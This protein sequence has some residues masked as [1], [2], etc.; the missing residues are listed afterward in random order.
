MSRVA[1]VTGAN[2]GIGR[3]VARQLASAGWTVLAG[4]RRD[5]VTAAS[6][7]ADETDGTVLPLTLDIA[8]TAQVM[9]AAR[10]VAEGPGRLDALVNNAGAIFDG[11][12]GEG[13]EGELEA[14]RRSFETNTL[15]ALRLTRAL[16]ELLR[17]D[18]GGAV[19]NV[20]S[21]MGAL[22]DMGT[23]YTGYRLSKTA[24]NAVTAMLDQELGPEVRVNSVC[25]GWVQTDMGGAGATRPVQEGARGVVWAATLGPDGPSGGFFRDGARIAW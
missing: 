11:K 24:L 2:R 5:A 17:A 19:V 22:N 4:S 6:A 15:G 21:G 12:V 16:S 10:V 25:P 14:A 8:N 18:G 20:S 13:L 23:G 3:E 7:L 1:L 9:A